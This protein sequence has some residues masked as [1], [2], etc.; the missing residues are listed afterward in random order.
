MLRTNLCISSKLEWRE[1]GM[2]KFYL[3][4]IAYPL[5]LAQPVHAMAIVF[6]SV[7]LRTLSTFLITSIH[8]SS[9]L[10][11]NSSAYIPIDRINQYLSSFTTIRVSYLCARD[12]INSSFPRLSTH[13]KTRSLQCLS[14]ISHSIVKAWS[15]SGN[16]KM[17]SQYVLSRIISS[18]AREHPSNSE[19]REPGGQSTGLDRIM[20]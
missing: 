9:R 13:R 11:V 18:I 8:P 6:G 5:T 4:G 10:V 16:L 1:Y 17:G 19:L 7:S 15:R 14:M 3:S 20:L 2:T 12:T